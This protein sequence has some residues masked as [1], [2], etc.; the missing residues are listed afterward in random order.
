MTTLA[1]VDSGPLYAALDADDDHNRAAVDVLRDS[2]FDLVIPTLVIAEVAYLVEARLGA[3][4]EAEFLRSISQFRIESPT[5]D[6]LRIAA[7][8]ERYADF[9]LGT[10]DAS[11]IA[12]AERL[13]TPTVITLDRRHFQA[14]RP[15]HCD[16]FEILPDV[17]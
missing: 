5:P 15:A 1:I 17:P 6:W 8:V 12:L 4:V 16:A 3:R 14:V 7:L 9:P 13:N 2:R 10:V 11:V